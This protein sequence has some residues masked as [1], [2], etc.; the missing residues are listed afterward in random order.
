[1]IESLKRLGVRTSFLPNDL[2]EKQNMQKVVTCL[3]DLAGVARQLGFKPVIGEEEQATLPPSQQPTETVSA[4]ETSTNT[5]EGEMANPEE[6]E[7]DFINLLLKN[8]AVKELLE[9]TEVQTK[10]FSFRSPVSNVTFLF[11]SLRN[12]NLKLLSSWILLLKN[13]L[14]FCVLKLKN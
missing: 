2:V 9:R 4:T 14:R 12:L 13:N 7:R 8:D 10:V 3:L 11:F 6:C 5:E 1:L